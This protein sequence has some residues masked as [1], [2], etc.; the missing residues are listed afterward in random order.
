VQAKVV[1]ISETVKVKVRFEGEPDI[2]TVPASNV[3]VPLKR[4]TVTQV[5]STVLPPS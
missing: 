4:V 5:G 1:E 2:I 3:L